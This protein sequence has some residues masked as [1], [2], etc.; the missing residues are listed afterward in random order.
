MNIR[1]I[2]PGEDQRIWQG[3]ASWTCDG[4]WA[5]PWRI[6]PDARGLRYSGTLYDAAQCAVGVRAELTTDATAIHLDVRTET[7]MTSPVDVVIDGRL[8]VEMPVAK[9]ESRLSAA[10][11][12]GEHA[13]EVWL[14][15]IGVLQ[16]GALRLEGARIAVP[17]SVQRPQ[18]IAYGSSITHSGRSPGPSRTWPAMVARS[19]GWSLTCLGFSGDCH[20]DQVVAR[21]IRDR[22]ADLISICAGI[23]IYNRGTFSARTLGPALSGFL[24]TV[25]DRHPRTPITVMSPICSPSREDTVNSAGLTLRDVRSLVRDVVT[26]DSAAGDS[27]LRYVDG[28][29]VLRPEEA[30][31]LPDG[32]H[33]SAEGYRLMA[34]RLA[35]LLSTESGILR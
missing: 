21:T 26:Q 35:P 19:N 22:T 30:G 17:T 6:R 29:T 8:A 5:Q 10:L 33:P 24:T 15:H 28:T 7:P 27:C 2:R 9:G 34:D 3:V 1:E 18:W 25:R 14:P 13:V 4:D 31:L 23:N 32:L 20:L 12:E 16:V 11:P